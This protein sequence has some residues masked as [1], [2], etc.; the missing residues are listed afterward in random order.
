MLNGTLHRYTC[1]TFNPYNGSLKRT[2]WQESP[3]PL[4]NYFSRGGGGRALVGRSVVVHATESVLRVRIDGIGAVAVAM[5]EAFHPH[6][7]N[8]L[9][10]WVHLCTWEDRVRLHGYQTARGASERMLANSSASGP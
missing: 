8:L 1:H 3:P 2:R 7:P 10:P 6:Q 4:Q 5:Q 9:R